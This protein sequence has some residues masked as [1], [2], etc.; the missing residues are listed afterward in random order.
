M[1]WRGVHL[2]KAARL[3]MERRN[4]VVEPADGTGELHLPIEDLAY[5]IIDT[6]EASITGALMARMSQCAV[7]VMGCDERHMPAWAAMPWGLHHRQAEVTAIQLGCSLPTAKRLW[8]RIVTAKVNAQ[9][10]TLDRV[11]MDGARK[12]RA[13][14]A[15]VRSGDAGNIEARAAS[16]YFHSLFP[17]R[18]FVRHA[19]DLPN[20]MLDYGYALA[21]SG[22][23]RHLC[24]HGFVPSIGLHHRSLANPFNLADD[25]IEPYRPLVDEAVVR[26]L[27]DRPTGS[28]L[29]LEDR[30]RMVGLL[31]EPVVFDGEEVTIFATF[32]LAVQSLRQ[33]METRDPSL[34]RFPTNRP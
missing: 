10:A 11:G 30:R 6:P 21:R 29:T 31:D 15:T 14:A 27:A 17:D 28:T 32:A 8:Q 24:A 5:I 9:A 22:L 12:L 25:L 33:A 2:S 19:K 4:L 18:A 3:R 34:L 7:M 20:A 16:H 13:L 26:L 1:A 23:A